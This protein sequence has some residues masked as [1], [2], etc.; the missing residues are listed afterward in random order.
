MAVTLPPIGAITPGWTIGIAS[1]NGK[2]TSVQVEGGAGE[3]ILVPGSGG[4]QTSLG[5]STNTSGMSML[6]GTPSS[7]SAPC[8]T[9]ALQ[10]DSNF[11]YF[12]TAPNTWK[13]A[14][15]SSF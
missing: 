15:W 6:I 5:L 12:C 10:S 2:A 14:A 7:S 11:L 13:R 1:D 9:G 3:K 4:A 8:Q